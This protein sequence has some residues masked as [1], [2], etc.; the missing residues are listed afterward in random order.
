M[1]ELLTLLAAGTAS[2]AVLLLIP[3]TAGSDAGS[4]FGGRDMTGLGRRRTDVIGQHGDA[5]LLLDLTAAL[6]SAGVGVEAAL[7]RLAAAVPGAEALAGMHRALAAGASWDQA[8]DL[9]SEDRQLR[10]FIDHMSFAY[11]TGAPSARM[12]QAA[13]GRARAEQRHAAESAAEKLGVKMML[14][15]GA[16]F[17]PAFIV[18]GVVP[19]VVSMLPETLGM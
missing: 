18:L 16:C 6:L 17:L 4:T 7:A 5:G 13:A 9:V 8:A 14:P 2:A 10:T 19:V 11:A 3:A 15:L 1:S 12:L